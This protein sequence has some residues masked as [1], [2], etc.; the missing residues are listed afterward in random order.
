MLQA[1]NASKWLPERPRAALSAPPSG[2]H[3]QQRSDVFRK[4]GALQHTYLA[5]AYL[6]RLLST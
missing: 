4:V 5:V 1:N 2:R 3:K 6:T